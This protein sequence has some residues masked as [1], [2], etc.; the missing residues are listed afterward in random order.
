MP[1]KL[2]KI[3]DTQF[4]W[5]RLAR[6]YRV[7]PTFRTGDWP[8][9]PTEEVT[10]WE[11]KH[12]EG[13]ISEI[14]QVKAPLW[15]DPR[16]KDIIVGSGMRVYPPFDA[17]MQDMI[18][19]SLNDVKIPIGQSHVEKFIPFSEDAV[20]GLTTATEVGDASP[21]YLL[22]IDRMET[23]PHHDDNLQLFLDL[24]RQYSQQWWV[25]SSTDPFDLG[26]R[27]SF[28]IEKDYTPRLKLR[29]AGADAS[30]IWYGLSATQK[31]IGFEQIVDCPS[32]TAIGECLR[33][34]TGLDR[35]IGL[36]LDA[37]VEFMTYHDERAILS[38]AIALDMMAAKI[39]NSMSSKS[40]KK[41]Y[42]DE[43]VAQSG[44]VSRKDREIIKHLFI[45]RGHIAHG[46][47]PHHLRKDPVKIVYYMD[48]G[49]RSLG[50][51]LSKAHAI[52]WQ[53]FLD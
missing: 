3:S 4:R 6:Y 5:D 44:I 10:S 8:R 2:R 12:L 39:H 32:W 29:H 23:D 26:F 11:D 31:F 37:V 15:V 38:I 50:L 19:N 22:R 33:A 14:Y 51:Y 28:E 34:G 40:M 21:K 49:L 48:A 16:V 1:K 25:G 30:G 53:K 17:N 24:F 41:K 36:M 43:A 46:R 18:S 52:G 9:L 27:Q 7:V 45:D 35:S 20:R 13:W 42:G 47:R